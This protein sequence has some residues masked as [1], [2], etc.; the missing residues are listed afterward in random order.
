[1][2]VDY[3]QIAAIVRCDLCGDIIQ[4]TFRHDFR[5]CSCLGLFVDGG[6]DY[7]RIG[8]NAGTFTILKE[9]GEREGVL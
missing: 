9:H 4:S 5:E 3:S 2:K 1:M 7:L 6:N 8:A